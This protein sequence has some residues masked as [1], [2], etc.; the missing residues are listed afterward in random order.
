MIYEC[1]WQSDPLNRLVQ[2]EKKTHLK[3]KEIIIM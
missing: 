2:I 3:C 1:Q